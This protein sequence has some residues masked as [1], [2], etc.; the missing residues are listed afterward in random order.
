MG[1]TLGARTTWSDRAL[2]TDG[3]P[4]PLREARFVAVAGDADVGFLL[5]L[6]RD[7]DAVREDLWCS[8]ERAGGDGIDRCE[9]IL[10]A[11]LQ[12]QAGPATDDPAGPRTTSSSTTTTTT[13]TTPATAGGSARTVPARL[14]G[15]A[16]SLPTTCGVQEQ[17]ERHGT[18]R[19]GD[20][21]LSWRVTDDMEAAA[22]EAEALL[23]SLGSD[24]EPVP[25]P[26][27]LG[28]EAS[29]CRGVP[30]VVVGTAFVDGVAVIATC[31]A[32][33]DADARASAPCKTL[34][35]GSW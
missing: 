31:V 1:N 30:R 23:A 19:C 5:G 18:Y 15:R 26:C 29:V 6:S 16:L 7:Q 17:D 28:Y 14:R 32:K 10:T 27:S 13:T 22:G 21:A 9:A 20:V 2:L 35:N 8:G 11:L 24:E 33:D 3:G 12:P 4:V 25:M 34:L